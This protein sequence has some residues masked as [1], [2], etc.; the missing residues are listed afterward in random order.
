[1]LKFLNARIDALKKEKDKL[2]REIEALYKRNQEAEQLLRE[3]LK[4][5][6]EN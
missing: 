5:I 6:T 4:E 2:E 3:I 1:M